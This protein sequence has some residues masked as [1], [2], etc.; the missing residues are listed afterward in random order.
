MVKYALL[1]AQCETLIQYENEKIWGKCQ[2][3]CISPFM[4]FRLIGW[5][6]LNGLKKIKWPVQVLDPDGP[7]VYIKSDDA[8]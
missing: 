6:T 3:D 7:L 2:R 8:K 5:A 4:S 1:E